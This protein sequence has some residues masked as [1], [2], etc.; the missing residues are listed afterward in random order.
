L[1]TALFEVYC[2]GTK[3]ALKVG[4]QPPPVP[5][6]ETNSS[7]DDYYNGEIS[8]PFLA[9][10]EADVSLVMYYAPWDFDSQMARNEIEEVANQFS[11]QV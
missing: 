7:V 4:L 2:I 10:A 8:T 1:Y 5:F 11:D 6:F 9:V 3:R